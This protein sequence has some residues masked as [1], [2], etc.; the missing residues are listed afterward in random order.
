L[1]SVIFYLFNIMFLNL[2]HN[3]FNDNIVF[4]EN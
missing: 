4:V 1:G 3:S 2:V